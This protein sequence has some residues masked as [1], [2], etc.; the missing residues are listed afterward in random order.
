MK[1]PV[2]SDWDGTTWCRW[3]ICWPDSEQWRGILRGLITLPMRGWTW[4]ERTGDFSTA[5]AAGREI[6]TL[7]L[8]LNGVL[9]A[10]NDTE[11]ADSFNNIALAI[12]G[13]AIGSSGA[14]CCSTPEIVINN[15]I[16]GGTNGGVGTD[17]TPIFGSAPAVT[18]APGEYPPE[19]ETL[20]AYSV[21]KCRNAHLLVD[22][23]GGTLGNLAGFEFNKTVVILGFI[24]ACIVAGLVFPPGLLP[25]M[26]GLIIVLSG[27]VYLLSQAQTYIEE[28]RDELICLLYSSNGTEAAMEGIAAFLDTMVAFFSV[29]SPLGIAVKTIAMMLF[30]T[31]TVNRLFTGAASAG[32]PDATCS[33]ADWWVCE[34]GTIIDSGSDFITVEAVA[35]AD[36]D[37]LTA[38]AYSDDDSLVYLTASTTDWTAPSDN[39]EFGSAWDTRAEACGAGLGFD[40]QNTSS[41]D[42][43]GPYEA[44]TFQHRGNLP[45]TVTYTR[46]F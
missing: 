9:M 41:V 8:P 38:V 7:N 19:Y 21:E 37:Y 20:E 35:T 14:G 27:E 39:P 13:L 22:A 42:E 36:F 12:R 23:V 10:C 44:R 28:H 46:V 25:L 5:T 34:F 33:C 30:N 2:P 1:L 32:Y 3:A 24:A 40:W 17:S 29:S 11:L 6:F 26:V 45:F 18:L 31:D 16:Q 43:I 15:T 4:D